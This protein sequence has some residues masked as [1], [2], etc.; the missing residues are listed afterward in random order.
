MIKVGIIDSDLAARKAT[1]LA[2]INSA[3]AINRESLIM[4]VFDIDSIDTIQSYHLKMQPDVLVLDIIGLNARIVERIK[5]LFIHSEII[6]VNDSAHLKTVHECFRGGGVSYL[7]KD[8]LLRYLFFAIT[9]TY[10]GG[11][12]LS[13]SICRAITKQYS[14]HKIHEDLLTARELQIAYG[15]IDGLSY[16]LIAHRYS[17]SLDTV[18]VYI[19]R[20]YRKLKINSKGE[21]FAQLTA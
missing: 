12:F 2:L 17:I 18:R 3:K 4:V 13:P 19:K 1:K 6:V 9:T 20:V 21:L 14:D 11:S 16:K 15:L 10:N 5:K 7:L 8:T